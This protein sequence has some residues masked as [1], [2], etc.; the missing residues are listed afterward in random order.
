MHCRTCILF[1][2]WNI[3]ICL[4]QIWMLVLNANALIQLPLIQCCHLLSKSNADCDFFL[5]TWIKMK[6]KSST[7][8]HWEGIIHRD[9]FLA[10]AWLDHFTDH[11]AIFFVW[12]LQ[13]NLSRNSC[14]CA[15]SSIAMRSLTTG[16][17]LHSQ[18]SRCCRLL[19]FHVVILQHT[20]EIVQTWVWYK[21]FEPQVSQVSSVD[22]PSTEPSVMESCRV[23]H[24]SGVYF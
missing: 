3:S 2:V 18:L 17:K 7:L 5:H 6:I 14:G 11:Y 23:R 24:V 1:V 15:C 12:A 13:G 22:L 21:F 4:V 19:I 9:A 20:R 8:V 10:E 16:R